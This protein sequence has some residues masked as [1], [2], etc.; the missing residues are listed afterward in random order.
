MVLRFLLRSWLHRTAEEKVRQKVAEMAR[1]QGHAAAERQQT[2]PSDPPSK[3][4]H[5]GVVF[6]LG[7]EAGGLED[8]LEDVTS[9]RG[10]GFV[11]RQ[12]DLK[13]RRIAVVRCGAGRENAARATEAL[14][15]GHKPQWVVCCGFAGGLDPALCR[16]DVLMADRLVDTSQ[17]RL[18]LDLQVDRAALAASPGVHVGRLLTADRIVRLPEEKRSLGRQYDALAVDMESF[19]VAEACRRRK[20]RFLCV[21]VIHDA[22]DDELPADVEKLLAQETSAARLG[23]AAAAVWRR[24]SSLKD[25]LQLKEDA[26]LASDRLAKFLAAMIEQW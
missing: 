15:A 9:T 8:L 23:A 10:E 17:N 19:A 16:R 1:Q 22:V 25:M 14:I 11:V 4:C 6:A 18:T 26:L 21:R 3:P 5:L 12:G 2:G 24:P 20:I 7:I 13:G